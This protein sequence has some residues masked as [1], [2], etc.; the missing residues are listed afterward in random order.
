MFQVQSYV[1]DFSDCDDMPIRSYSVGATAKSKL[2]QDHKYRTRALSCGSQDDA[3]KGKLKKRFNVKNILKSNSK[4]TDEINDS[5]PYLGSQTSQ[6]YG[7]SRQ[8]DLMEMEFLPGSVSPAGSWSSSYSGASGRSRSGSKS[9][10]SR[11]RSTGNK[12]YSCDT[13]QMMAGCTC[14]IDMPSS[15]SYELSSILNKEKTENTTTT[16]D[17]ASR[18][19]SVDCNYMPMSSESAS[20][21]ISPSQELVQ[22]HF[23]LEIV[24]SKDS[25]KPNSVK[26]PVELEKSDSYGDYINIDINYSKPLNKAS[27]PHTVLAKNTSQSVHLQTSTSSMQSTS[28]K[29]YRDYMNLQ[30]GENSPIMSEKEFEVKK[31]PKETKPNVLSNAQLYPMRKQQSAPGG[32]PG[33]SKTDAILPARKSSCPITSCHETNVTT[34]IQNVD[35]KL[36]IDLPPAYENISFPSQH[37]AKSPYNSRPSS[38]CNEA[39]LNYASLDLAPTSEEDDRLVS[40]ASPRLSTSQNSSSTNISGSVPGEDG[41]CATGLSYAEID[42]TRSEGLRTTTNTVVES[43]H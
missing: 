40:R 27:S 24:D 14:P 16:S 8:E 41:D 31:L 35:T 1:S 43:R 15:T 29:S 38:V 9:S 19:S 26:P 30:F 20:N 33:M 13:C 5:E 10:S 37:S 6:T 32:L 22:Q 12:Q 23:M 34:F 42:F 39:G 25:N 28:N 11:Y 36:K 17:S 3:V 7:G 2:I 4:E 18:Q 21:K